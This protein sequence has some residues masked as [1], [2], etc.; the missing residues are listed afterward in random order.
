LRIRRGVF[1]HRASW[2]WQAVDHHKN[3][4]QP[5]GGIARIVWM[6]KDLKEMLR[7]EMTKIA[8]DSGLGSDF[9]DKIADETIGTSTEEILSFLEEKQHP[10]LTMDPLF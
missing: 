9:V 5:V 2:Y 7:A 8:E 6:P 10:A 3:S 4:S 1:S